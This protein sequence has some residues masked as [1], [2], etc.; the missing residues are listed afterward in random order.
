MRPL[1]DRPRLEEF[2]VRLDAAFGLP[3]RLYLIGETSQL[4]EGWRPWVER[5]ELTA[6]IE[7]ADRE[8]F[9]AALE[10]LAAAM[11]VEIVDESP[12]DVIPLPDGYRER[13]RDASVGGDGGRL[14]IRHF[15]PYSVAL[16]FIARGDEP[17][18]HLVLAYL[19]HGWMTVETMD[20]LLQGTLPRFSLRTI[21][22]DPAEFRRKYHGLLQ[23]WQALR[24]GAV[25]RATP[26]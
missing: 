21:Q 7:T 15:D 25:H 19:S 14:T 3:G 26:A 6:E 9:R 24:P 11:D 5:I 22:Q 23:M 13:A 1:V 8:A 10:E 12:G 4:A 20:E 18:Y 16:R 2:L 17:D